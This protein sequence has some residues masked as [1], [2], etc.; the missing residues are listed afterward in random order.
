MRIREEN[1]EKVI[2]EIEYHYNLNTTIFAT[3]K[4]NDLRKEKRTRIT[5]FLE[6]DQHNENKRK[7]NYAT[8]KRMHDEKEE[9]PRANLDKTEK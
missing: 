2:E 7:K 8:L 6:E 3:E 5:K 4:E 1:G 9:T